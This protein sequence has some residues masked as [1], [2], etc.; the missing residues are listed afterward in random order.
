MWELMSYDGLGTRIANDRMAGQVEQEWKGMDAEVVQEEPA[1][2]ILV[3]DLGLETGKKF[4]KSSTLAGWLMYMKKLSAFFYCIFK[5]LK[6][7]KTTF[8]PIILKEW[9]QLPG[10]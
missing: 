1:W 5:N 8:F 10:R 6:I 9:Y 2:R 3:W 4:C 7:K